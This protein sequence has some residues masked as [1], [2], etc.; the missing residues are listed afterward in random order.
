MTTALDCPVT[1]TELVAAVRQQQVRRPAVA[2]A[3]P[4]G[5]TSRSVSVVGAHPGAGATAVSV[6][7]TD[8]LAA[9]G[10]E[11]TLVDWAATPDAFGC[12]EVEVE[13]G[14]VGLRAGRRRNAFIVRSEGAYADTVLEPAISVVDGHHGGAKPVVV[15]R[16][17][18]PSVGKA[19]QFVTDESLLAVL[20]AVRWPKVVAAS[21]GPMISH[22][23]EG[24]R[25]V[26]FPHHR[27]LEIHGADPEP[28]PT[29]LLAAGSRLIELLWPDLLGRAPKNRWKGSR[30]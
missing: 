14:S 3:P 8:A 16:A 27:A 19:E 17:T 11:V 2:A 15:C 24:G 29:S 4:A 23:V 1:V 28:T 6:A 26:F 18:L 12:A 5:P 25:V 13:S 7:I 22:A 10:Q 30:Q 20:G 9:I 21:L